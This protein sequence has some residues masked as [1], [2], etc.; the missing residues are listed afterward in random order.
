LRS[1]G[2][3]SFNFPKSTVQ[4]DLTVE[5]LRVAVDQLE[6]LELRLELFKLCFELLALLVVVESETDAVCLGRHLNELLL[7]LVLVSQV[8]D[9]VLSKDRHLQEVFVVRPNV[10]VLFKEVLNLLCSPCRE[11]RR[12]WLR[13]N[14]RRNGNNYR[15]RFILWIEEYSDLLSTN[16]L[17]IQLLDR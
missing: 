3:H 8:D 13:I 14:Y 12:S 6:G 15:Q 17:T 2:I 7:L 9:D 11:R 1:E 4:V 10:P 5:D 16:D